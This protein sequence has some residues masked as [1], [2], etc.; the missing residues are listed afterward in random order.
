V[1]RKSFVER[2][3]EIIKRYWKAAIRGYQFMR[4]VPE[5]FP[6][7][8]FVEA[9]LRVDNPDEAERMRDLRPLDVMEGRFHPMDGQ[10]RI[11]GVWRILQEHQDA[12]VLS[13]SITRADAEEVVRQELVREAW[14]EVSQTD[15]VK[16]NIERLQPV[17]E[18]VG[19]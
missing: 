2:N 5:H 19:Y 12:G 14:A 3:P 6:F 13:R 16:R 15:E 9:K 11:E 18:R 8:R 1:A 17:I 10:L 7:Q 4:I